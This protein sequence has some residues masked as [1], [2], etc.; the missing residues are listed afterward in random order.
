MDKKLHQLFQS[1]YFLRSGNYKAAIRIYQQLLELFDHNR[2]GCSTLRC[3]TSMP[4]WGVLDSL[5]S[6]GL[7]DEMP[8]LSWL[9]CKLAKRLPREFVRKVLAFI[10]LYD[11]FQ[12]ISAGLSPMR[13]NFISNMRGPVPQTVAAKTRVQLLLQLNLVVLHAIVRR[14]GKPTEAM[15]RIQAT[16]LVFYNFRLSVLRS[17]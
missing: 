2:A 8:F 17:W 12:L 5:L 14:G 4:C 3:T 11:S 13:R 9:H 15:T 6:A 1:T 10:Y 16:G 7:Y